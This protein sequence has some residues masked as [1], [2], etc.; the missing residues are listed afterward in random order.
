VMAGLITAMISIPGGL[1][2]VVYTDFVQAG[3][4]LFGFT[5]LTR[6]AL[7]QGGGLAGLRAA[8]PVDYFSFLGF[9]SYGTWSIVSLILTLVL[10]V[11][12]DPGRRL[13]MYS[14][15]NEWAAKWGMLVASVIVMAF[16]VSVGIVGM[17]AFKLNPH[18]T[19]SDQA[20]PWLVTKVLSPWVA[21]LVVVSVSSAIFS[22][23]NGNAA[24]AGTFFVRHIYPLVTGHYPARSLVTVRRALACVFL[25][26]TAMAMYTGSIVGFVAKFLPVTMSGLAIII[27]MGYFWKRATWQGA[28]AALVVTPVV[29]LALMFIPLKAAFWSSPAIPSALAGTLALIVVSL[30]TK[31]NAGGF[32]E[33]A[34]EM[35]H[36]REAVEKESAQPNLVPKP[37]ASRP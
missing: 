30:L 25:V 22:S 21:A 10:A 15:R 37:A 6:L 8:V 29:S 17:Y 14:A 3:I 31:P 5:V 34:E 32:E 11:V 9:Q 24:A 35:A 12:A 36:E 27:L 28:L 16:S 26:S 13:T 33:V 7:F 1:K 4:L 23:A 18:L 20:L 2:T 19:S